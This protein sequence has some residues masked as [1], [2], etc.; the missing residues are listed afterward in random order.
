MFATVYMDVFAPH[1]LHFMLFMPIA[2]ALLAL[3]ALPTFNIVP[4]RQAHECPGAAMT[5]LP[6]H[7]AAQMTSRHPHIEQLL[8]PFSANAAC[9]AMILILDFPVR[10]HW[11]VHMHC[12]SLELAGLLNT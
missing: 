6:P 10:S 12:S 7:K 5:A 2:V 1:A 11:H 3:I 4:F 8:L 9:H